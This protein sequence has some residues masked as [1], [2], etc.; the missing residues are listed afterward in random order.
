MISDKKGNKLYRQVWIKV[1]FPEKIFQPKIFRSKA[2]P[3]QGFNPA[4]IADLQ[5][6]VAD[7]LETLYPFWDFKS[8]ELASRGRVA[9]YVFTFA[10]YRAV[11]SAPQQVDM[12]DFTL[13]SMTESTDEEK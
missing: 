7:K 9:R 2:G 8:V 5:M 3:H 4:G 10:G 1:I 11:Q 12:K 6:Q 13:P